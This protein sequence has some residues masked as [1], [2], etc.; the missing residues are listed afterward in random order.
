MRSCHVVYQADWSKLA[1]LLVLASCYSVLSPYFCSYIGGSQ[2]TRSS[3]P[4]T[5]VV[6]I[7]I[8]RREPE[9]QASTTGLHHQRRSNARLIYR[10][11]SVNSGRVSQ[12]RNISIGRI[13]RR[14]R[15]FAPFSTS[16][17]PFSSVCL[18]SALKEHEAYI[19]ITFI[20]LSVSRVRKLP[21]MT[22]ERPTVLTS[23]RQTARASRL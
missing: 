19:P 20:G 11:R 10:K 3:S 6:R 23:Q 17:P 1:R 8:W 21:P 9:T 14:K 22:K 15:R 5:N 2:R 4:A 16:A 13:S 18:I 7:V 12:P